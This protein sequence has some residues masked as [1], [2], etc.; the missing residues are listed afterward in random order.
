MIRDALETTYDV[1]N[2]RMSP[3]LPRGIARSIPEEA[4]RVWVGVL[5]LAGVGLGVYSL[6]DAYN[7]GRI[8]VLSTPQPV[9]RIPGTSFTWEQLRVSASA[10]RAGVP[11]LITPQ[12]R[13]NLEHLTVKL[14]EPLKQRLDGKLTVT[15]GYRSPSVN[16]LI[17]GSSSSQHMSGEAVDLASSR[18][19]SS[20][21]FA[22]WFLAQG[23]PF[24][25]IV[26]YAPNQSSH[27]HISL[28]RS[29]N[30]GRVTYMNA[31]GN[32]VNGVYPGS[33]AEGGEREEGSW[34][35]WVGLAGLHGSAGL[36]GVSVPAYMG[37]VSPGTM[38]AS[39]TA[40]GGCGCDH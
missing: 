3:L 17:G 39:T 40:F 4:D 5:V 26:W 29:G 22:K 21:A 28:K 33:Q 7:K 12:A 30:R 6:V 15:S 16:K 2:M 11:N 37:R 10:S 9:G 24:D 36:A 13:R 38:A 25:Q 23:L 32:Y 1:A 18:F 27:I 34:L 14:L 19:S 35:S 31:Q 8:G 20:E